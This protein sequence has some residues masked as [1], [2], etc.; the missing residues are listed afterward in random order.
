ML[1][2]IV[3]SLFI[4]TIKIM[5][6]QAELAEQLVVV[7]AQVAKV[8]VEVSA[9]LDKVAVLEAAIASNGQVSPDLQ[10]AFDS[11]KAQ[12]VLVDELIPDAPVAPVE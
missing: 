8:G 3:I 11:L 7:A 1:T 9:T 5:S 4:F 6:T 10:A 12:V 2:L